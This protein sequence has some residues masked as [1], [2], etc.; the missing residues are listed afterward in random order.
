MK[1]F[2]IITIQDENRKFIYDIEVPTDVVAGQLVTD[3]A[4]VLSSYQPGAGTVKSPKQ[5]YCQRLK[6]A[7]S[8]NE[9]FGSA[10]IWTGDIIVIR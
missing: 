5:L 2:V 9:T 8:A 3:I 1:P 4:E 7:L 6:K 10:G